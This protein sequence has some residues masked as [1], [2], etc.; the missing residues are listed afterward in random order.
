MWLLLTVGYTSQAASVGASAFQNALTV[1]AVLA[2]PQD[3][4]PRVLSDTGETPWPALQLCKIQ[5]EVEFTPGTDECEKRWR[6][7]YAAYKWP[8]RIKHPTA[9][10]AM[11]DAGSSSTGN[12]G[13]YVVMAAPDIRKADLP[14]KATVVVVTTNRIHAA[15][16]AFAEKQQVDDSDVR[17]TRWKERM[18]S[19]V[20]E[21]RASTSRPRMALPFPSAY[22]AQSLSRNTAV[23]AESTY[24]TKDVDLIRTGRRVMAS[25]ARREGFRR[26]QSLL[27][28]RG[29]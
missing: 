17:V 6:E 27:E 11:H 12:R 18:A 29:K 22:A 20:P 8:C 3:A 26:L 10:S 23:C 5:A 19:I 2:R 15:I 14:N 25:A 9:M 7:M 24:P 1:A 21:L 13:E 28:G 4:S 16:G